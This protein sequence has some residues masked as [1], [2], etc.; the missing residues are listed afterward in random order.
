MYNDSKVFSESSSAWVCP[1]YNRCHVSVS[2]RQKN[3]LKNVYQ[4][5]TVILKPNISFYARN[6]NVQC[7]EQGLSRVSEHQFNQNMKNIQ[8]TQNKKIIQSLWECT[9]VAKAV[10]GT[11]S[12]RRDCVNMAVYRKRRMFIELLKHMGV[13]WQ[14]KRSLTP[15]HRLALNK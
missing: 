6:A 1:T 14:L 4:K 9:T 11:V 10:N 12:N 15:V 2:N 7:R 3:V 5:S 8:V 13:H